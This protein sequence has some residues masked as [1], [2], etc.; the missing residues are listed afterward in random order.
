MHLFEKCPSRMKQQHKTWIDKKI[1]PLSCA[2]IDNSRNSSVKHL[3]SE[4]KDRQK[5]FPWH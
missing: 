5:M 2:L 4:T 3:L 1:A